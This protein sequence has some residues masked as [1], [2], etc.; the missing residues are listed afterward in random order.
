MK[1]V[2]K[3]KVK[4]IAGKDKGKIG[5]IMHV[6]ASENKV[7]VGGINVFKKATKASKKNPQGGI[8]EVTKPISVSNV[9]LVCPSCDKPTRVGYS[10][11]K[12]GAK[13]R[14]CKACKGV[15]KE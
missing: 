1:L 14:I 7:V 15:I 2:K 11:S 4:V 3:D 13:D 6:L 12:A 5:E 9:T 10:V 8:I